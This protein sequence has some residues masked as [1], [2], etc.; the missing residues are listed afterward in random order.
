MR[1]DFRYR[2]G[3]EALVVREPAAVYEAD[4][5]TATSWSTTQEIG[6]QSYSIRIP[7]PSGLVECA[8]CRTRFTAAGPTGYA[9]EVE[10]CDM[11]LLEAA[12]ELGMVIAL[13]AVVR[14]FGTV[15]PSDHE[16]Y[17]EALAEIGAFARVYEKFAARSGPPR[18][19]RVPSLDSES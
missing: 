1:R 13:V 4:P 10:I 9:E 16:D 14:A 2:V 12:P 11:C 17:R 3:Q 7:A 8:R 18:V 15:A 5:E 19:F 6:L